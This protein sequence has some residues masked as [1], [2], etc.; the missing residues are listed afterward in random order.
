MIVNKTMASTPDSSSERT[1]FPSKPSR[2]NNKIEVTDSKVLVNRALKLVD[3]KI[4]VTDSKVSTNE[5]LDLLE[6]FLS[7]FSTSLVN[8]TRPSL[9]PSV[10]PNHVLARN[11]APVSELPPT[12]YVVVEGELP[13]SLNGTYIQKGPNPHH[14]PKGPHHFFEGD[15]MLHSIQFTD[16]QATFCSRYVKTYK[17][18][19]EDNVG[20][21]IFPNVITSFYSLVDLGRCVVAIGRVIKGQIDLIK[22]SI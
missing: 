20:F 21:P 22:V 7:F 17:Y 18:A 10:D 5:A 1:P 16:G 13:K 9:H 6:C 12:D 4:E 11:F 19:L 2:V 14:Q 3:T 15:G 8:F